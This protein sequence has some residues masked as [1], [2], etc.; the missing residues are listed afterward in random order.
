MTMAVNDFL[1]NSAGGWSGHGPVG[2]MFT[3][4]AVRM[5]VGMC[6]PFI[7]D[8]PQSPYRGRP[9]V[10]LGTG[11]MVW[12]EKVR[13]MVP[14][15]KTF[16]ISDLQARGIN[17]PV[18][19]ATSLR[20]GQWIQ[21]D[22]RLKDIARPRLRAW[23]DLVSRRSVGG[24]NAMGKM[25]FEYE[26]ISDSGIAVTDMDAIS[27]GR[28]SSPQ[29]KIRS[30]PL[31]ITH[32]DF[33]YSQR[34]LD[35]SAADG[36]TPASTTSGAHAARQVAERIE[37]FTLGTVT[38]IEYG[39]ET[40]GYGAHDGLSKI[41]GYISHP[42]RITKTDLTTPTGSN[43]EVTL[44]EI[45]SMRDTMYSYN[46]FG[47][48]IIYHSTDWDQYLDNDYARLGGNDAK[49]TLRRRILEI[50]TEGD[51]GAQITAVR[52]AD[53][54]TPALS[55]AF[56]LVM[57]DMSQDIEALNGMDITTVQWPELG[58]LKQ[59]WKVMAI[60]LPLIKYD[61]NGVAPIL[62]ARTA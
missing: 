3:S 24:F 16:L 51:G 7:E 53:F 20:K 32:A 5:D 36:K 31:P 62:H 23:S 58:G 54:L 22:T 48:Y 21:M 60:Q 61:Y 57:V 2:E 39:T 47:P 27:D 43:P 1:L 8:H 49:T 45:L 14:E 56:T 34:F 29:F 59:N 42:A 12:N 25:T 10:T 50:G 55:H 46:F 35:V 44:A 19:N 11:R 17:N 6:Q 28:M 38:G 40:A 26:V 9:C 33:W 4:R 15:R 37:G 52:R 13:D 30:V 41:Y 18:W